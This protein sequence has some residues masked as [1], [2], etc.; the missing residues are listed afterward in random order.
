MLASIYRALVLHR[1][2]L[3]FRR[4]GVDKYDAYPR[5]LPHI[6][7]SRICILLSPMVR[8]CHLKARHGLLK[9]KGCMGAWARGAYNSKGDQFT[10]LCSA[11][12]ITLDI[13]REE[14]RTPPPPSASSHIS[15]AQFH[16]VVVPTPTPPDFLKVAQRAQVHESQLVKLA[17]AIPSMI[18]LSIKKAMKPAKYILKRL[19]SIVEV[20]ESEVITLRKYVAAL[21]EPPSTSNTIPPEPAAIPH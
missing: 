13:P 3:A 10:L 2:R 16:T 9:H 5:S 8:P 17:K 14:N 21:S 19:C 18:Q 12:P 4:W 15:A 20:L 11:D 6:G 7:D 1:S